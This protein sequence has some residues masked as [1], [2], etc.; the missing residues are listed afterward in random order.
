MRT[1]LL[2]ALAVGF[3]AAASTQAALPNLSGTWVLQVDKSDFG[4]MAPVT[5]RTDV[6]Q[7]QEPK[8]LIKRTI[9]SSAGETTSDLVY[10]V[11]GKPY[12]NTV[13][14]TELTST[15]N[16]DG[17]VLV[18]VSTASVPQGDVTITDRYTLSADG[19][20]LTQDRTLSIQGQQL[21]Q[22]MV[23]QKQP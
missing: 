4:P 19:K 17:A 6:I 20:T 1:A 7:H 13:S 3:P 11:D 14:D 18:M 16:W 9:A 22:K 15:L 12:K 21:V 8:L 2:A 10:A 5:S 23:L